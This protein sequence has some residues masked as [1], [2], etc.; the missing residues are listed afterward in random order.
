MKNISVLVAFFVMMP[1]VFASCG[2]NQNENGEDKTI[3]T[4]LTDLAFWELNGPVKLC[5]EVE[6]DRQGQMVRIGD[7]NPFAIDAPYRDIDEE[8]YMEEFSKWGRNEEGRISSITGIEGMTSY[9]WRDGKV[10]RSEGIQEGTEYAADYEYDE[11][12]LLVKLVEYAS[13]VLDEEK[14]GEMSMWATTEYNY[15]EFDSHGNWIR[16]QVTRTY[17]DSDIFEDYEETRT[18]TY[19]E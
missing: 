1:L 5:D 15:L 3:V 19:F 11:Q 9:T 2:N 13:D 8:G 17:A 12:G 4:V 6:F 18:I 16:R 14:G 10:V 7:Y